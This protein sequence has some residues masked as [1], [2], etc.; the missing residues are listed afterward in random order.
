MASRP[1]TGPVRQSR[2]LQGEQP[3]NDGLSMMMQQPNTQHPK[4]K[5]HSL[6]LDLQMKEND[7]NDNDNDNGNGND[8]DDGND[9]LTIDIA[10]LSR[11]QTKVLIHISGTHGVEGFP[12]SAI[13]TSLLQNDTMRAYF[14]FD[15][16]FDHHHHHQEEEEE[17]AE[18]L[19]PTLVFV[20]A[21]NPYG[22]SKLRRF[23]ENNVDLNRNFLFPH[24]FDKVKA[25]DP[26][27][28]GYVDMM[29]FINPTQSLECSNRFGWDLFF[30]RAL[31]VIAR[32]GFHKM[33][34]CIV[35][36]NYHFPK[37]LFYGGD[38]LEQSHALLKD[39]LLT[40]LDTEKLEVVGIL[41]VHSGLG[42]SGFDTIGLVGVRPEEA[43]EIF[44][45]SEDH[46]HF[47]DYP[48]DHEASGEESSSDH[49]SDSD[50]DND[51]ALSGYDK[52]AGFVREGLKKQV[53]SS[54]TKVYPVTQEFGTLPGILVFKA[55]RAENAMYQYDP[56]N[57]HPK[58]SH[59]L[60][61][62][63]YFDKNPEWK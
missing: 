50:N 47:A 23:N 59:A 4:L 36:G 54:N 28:V 37:S 18:R 48:E 52:V 11:S 43:S 6:K 41:D 49:D 16:D 33:K 53:F 29:D 44:G 45:N 32:H 1:T 5:L 34:Q 8:N 60:R 55:M 12:G 2:R 42:K 35:T 39:F 7:G 13:Q 62:A 19:L 51:S 15:H 3:S 9:D 24:E 27:H 25:G 21:L 40:H 30:P 31:Y 17:D 58:Y 26:N 61:D 20:H 63:F 10:L 57:R 46:L 56:K 14:D 22:F 38:K